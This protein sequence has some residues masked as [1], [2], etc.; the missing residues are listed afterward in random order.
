MHDILANMKICT[1]TRPICENL[2]DHYADSLIP[3]DFRW[4]F[5]DL[6]GCYTNN[7]LYNLTAEKVVF[8]R[9]KGKEHGHL[10]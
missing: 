8:I 5:M 4:N 1:I 7:P 2:H 3:T 9:F 10:L 6:V